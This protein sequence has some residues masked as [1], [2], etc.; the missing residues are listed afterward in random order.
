[1][2]KIK[3][4]YELIGNTPIVS[5]NYYKKEMNLECNIFAKLE[6]Y[7]MTGSVKDRVALA[8]IEDAEKRG[9]LKPL[10]TIIEPTSGNTGIGLAAIGAT[11]GYSVIIV[12]PDTMSRER[13]DIL[14]AYGAK[15]ILTDGKAGMSGCIKKSEELNKKITNSVILNQFR[16]SANVE[17][18][19]KTTGFEI[20]TG[21]K[22]NIDI[23]VSGIGTAGTI[24]GVGTTLKEYNK[25]VKIVA[26]EPEG[27][28]VISKK[29]VGEHKIQGI[30]AGFIPPLFDY[31]IVDRIVTV[32]DKEAFATIK[33]LAKKEGLLV[34]LSSG[35][36]LC[37]ATKIAKE[38]QNKNIVVIFP[39]SGGKYLSTGVYQ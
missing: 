29:T 14:E 19:R 21:M 1:M 24:T 2:S 7:S 23:F 35:A 18:H 17:I 5:L 9:I 22:G 4:V 31:E 26:V 30:G 38:N 33:I 36:A 15:V 34:G 11:K 8:M 12:M 28:A 39:D 37:A 10:G 32:E 25:N 6:W 13:V 27:S 20:I 16:N 3:A